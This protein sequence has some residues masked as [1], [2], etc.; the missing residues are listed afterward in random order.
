M[1]YLDPKNLDIASMTYLI[2]FPLAPLILVP[3]MSITIFNWSIASK[4]RLVF[5]AL[6]MFMA[7]PLVSKRPGQSMKNIP[8]EE[9]E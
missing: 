4:I 7:D 6:P 5:T 2:N 8:W 3:S 1:F 9:S